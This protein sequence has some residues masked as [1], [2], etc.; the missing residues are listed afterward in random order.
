MPVRSCKLTCDRQVCHFVGP[1]KRLEPSI[2]TRGLRPAGKLLSS[3]KRRV[4]TPLLMLAV[5]A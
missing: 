4:G 2:T 3:V 1:A 5:A